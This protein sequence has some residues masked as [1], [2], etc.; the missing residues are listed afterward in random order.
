MVAR[1]FR[2]TPVVDRKGQLLGSITLKSLQ[3][4]AEQG[5]A[6]EEAGTS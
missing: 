1:S 2:I 3:E 4:L 6:E 5:W